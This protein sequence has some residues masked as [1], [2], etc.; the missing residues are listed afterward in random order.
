MSSQAR[1]QLRMHRG[2]TVA[3]SLCRPSIA[4]PLRIQASARSVRLDRILVHPRMHSGRSLWSPPRPQTPVARVP[5]S[6]RCATHEQ[7][8]FCVLCQRHHSVLRAPTTDPRRH[9]QF[10]ALDVAHIEG[11]ARFCLTCSNRGRE[12]RG[13]TRAR[14]GSVR[15]RVH[16]R[17]RRRPRA[18]AM[19]QRSL[20]YSAIYWPASSPKILVR[21]SRPHQE[22][23]LL[24]PIAMRFAAG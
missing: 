24:A 2:N 3:L 7:H 12:R 1:A 13:V 17:F 5:A 21:E 14:I 10:S 18:A 11:A 19:R 23:F 6:R 8:R 22:A 15:H 9:P 4:T 20:H 16:L